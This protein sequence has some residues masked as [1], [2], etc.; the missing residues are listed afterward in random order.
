MKIL[1][2]VLFLLAAS[3]VSFAQFELPPRF[4]LQLGP[5]LSNMNWNQGSPAPATPIKA[6]WELGFNIGFLLRI[7]LNEQLSLQPE[8]NFDF[9]NGKDQSSATNYQLAWLSMPVLLQYKLGSVSLFAGPEAAIL[10]AASQTVSGIKSNIT[11][12]TEERSIAAVAGVSWQFSRLFFVS[13][14]Y[15]QGASV[16]IEG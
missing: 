2:L 3:T 10:I 9:K 5:S 4:G 6:S 8:Y 16:A 1:L 14:R 11:H 13:A 15:E 12:D 7:P